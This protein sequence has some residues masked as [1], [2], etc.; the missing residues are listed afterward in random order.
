MAL[1]SQQ[2]I[3]TLQ[4]HTRNCVG[5]PSIICLLFWCI[6][7]LRLAAF[8]ATNPDYWIESESDFNSFYDQKVVTD[9][10]PDLLTSTVKAGLNL[11]TD[12]VNHPI[13]IVDRMMDLKDYLSYN[14]RVKFYLYHPIMS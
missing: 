2:V 3:F 8:D 10:H 9:L 4:M 1:L 11:V 12:E 13:G 7:S 14:K 5:K 6:N